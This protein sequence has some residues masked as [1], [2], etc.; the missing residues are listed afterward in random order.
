[1]LNIN[2]KIHPDK[3]IASVLKLKDISYGRKNV[4]PDEEFLQVGAKRCRLNEV[5]RAHKHLKC[6][7]I[8][9][10]T[11]ESW[12]IIE[13]RVKGCFYD[14]NDKFLCSVVL[15]RGDCAVIYRGGHS[16]EVLEDGTVFY[17]FKNGPYQG[18]EKDK[19][20]IGEE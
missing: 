20:F 15:G 10:I 6:E 12:I 1:M 16:L 5:F 19:E 3:L 14:L 18:I 2:S 7:K 8:A 4:T 17:E 13:G 11:Q 9:K